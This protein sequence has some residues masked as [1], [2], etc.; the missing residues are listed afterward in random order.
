MSISAKAVY[1]D[2]RKLEDADVVASADY[3]EMANEV[4]ADPSIALP[5]RQA[6]ANRLSVADRLME[7][8]TIKEDDSY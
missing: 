6:V 7:V 5:M 4:L 2:L 1:H 3:R 8:R